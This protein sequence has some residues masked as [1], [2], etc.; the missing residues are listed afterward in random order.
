MMKHTDYTIKATRRALRA[1]FL[2]LLLDICISSGL[3][4]QDLQFLKGGGMALS[5]YFELLFMGFIALYLSFI[6]IFLKCYYRRVF[7]WMDLA[8]C[9]AILNGHTG[10][11]ACEVR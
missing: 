4:G 10:H 3:K 11:P 6:V 2:C 5:R 9:L 8:D 7:F 1:L